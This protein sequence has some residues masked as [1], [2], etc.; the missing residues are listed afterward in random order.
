VINLLERGQDHAKTEAELS[1]IIADLQSYSRGRLD[2]AAL[3]REF[4]KTI[5]AMESLKASFVL[6]QPHW[7]ERDP[8]DDNLNDIL[9]YV[10]AG[11]IAKL[12]C[13]TILAAVP[14]MD[15]ESLAQYL[16]SVHQFKLNLRPCEIGFRADPNAI[17]SIRYSAGFPGR[18]RFAFSE[19]PFLFAGLK[20]LPLFL[21]DRPVVNYTLAEL[22]QKSDE[23]LKELQERRR[24]IVGAD[25]ISPGDPLPELPYI[26][27]LWIFLFLVPAYYLSAGFALRA[28]K[29]RPTNTNEGRWVAFALLP[30]ET[31]QSA[32]NHILIIGPLVLLAAMISCC[33]SLVFLGTR[34]NITQWIR[35]R[36]FFV[37][38]L[39]ALRGIGVDFSAFLN[40][41]QSFLVRAANNYFIYIFLLSLLSSAGL[42][43]WTYRV[44]R[45]CI[46]ALSATSQEAPWEESDAETATKVAGD[47]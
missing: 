26:F 14:G 10:K 33:P 16:F 13:L 42:L 35:P 45:R 3:N 23:A 15:G 38:P 7:S 43:F 47:A 37:D 11:R 39:Y 25:R 34:I 31:L 24:F 27:V 4:S 44:R 30:Q 12:E 28:I 40:E 21:D 2:T 17:N 29:P 22:S 20:M 46:L 8:I 1:A 6:N 9:K 18:R 32:L 41:D 5:W 36:D 19:T